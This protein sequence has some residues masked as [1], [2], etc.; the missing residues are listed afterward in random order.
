MARLLILMSLPPNK[1]DIVISELQLCLELCSTNAHIHPLTFAVSLIYCLGQDLEDTV[2]TGAMSL[3]WSSESGDK[4]GAIEWEMVESSEGNAIDLSRA[5]TQKA[6]GEDSITCPSST[7]P[8][9]VWK[10]QHAPAP[11]FSSAKVR[12][13]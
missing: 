9:V 13:C 5:N 1:N 12:N 4:L 11:C 8:S 7:A 6:L 3:A 10:D 2:L